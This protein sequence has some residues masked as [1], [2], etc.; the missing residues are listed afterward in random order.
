[1]DALKPLGIDPA[2]LIAY[3]INFVILVFLLR[4]FLYRPILNMLA[5]RRQKI[6]ESLAQA[7][8]VRQEADIQRADFQR[9]L[10]ETR[11][12]SQEAAAR[13]AQETEKMREA[14][15]VEARKEAEQIREQ[16]RQQ[17]AEEAQHTLDN[18]SPFSGEPHEH[19]AAV[20]IVDDTVD[21]SLSMQAIHQAA[22]GRQRYSQFAGDLAHGHGCA[23][24]LF[25]KKQHRYLRQRKTAP[26][27]I[28]EVGD[29]DVLA[30]LGNKDADPLG[31]LARTVHASRSGE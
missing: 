19:Y 17:I 18:R 20:A 27:A 7:D 21:Q 22:G 9:E 4:L 14:I 15:L 23:A 12:T 5:E 2:L 8:K 26:N 10:E 11:K 3:L 16:A 13:A 28:D 1:M 30:N 24:G 29:A 25:Q 6:Q 31:L